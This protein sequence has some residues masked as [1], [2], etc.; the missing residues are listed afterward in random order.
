VRTSAV[1]H[2]GV[3]DLWNEVLRHRD[4]LSTDH[5]GSDR[6]RRQLTTLIRRAA[7]AELSA[8]VHG[9]DVPADLAERVANGETDPWSAARS[10][11]S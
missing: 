5:R 3:T 10:L 2:T 11:I 1:E 8:R 9:L 4:W 6:R 7:S